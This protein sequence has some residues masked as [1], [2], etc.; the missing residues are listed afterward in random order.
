MTRLPAAL[1]GPIW[2]PRPSLRSPRRRSL[3]RV[4]HWGE[5]PP[6]TTPMAVAA[7][8]L[9]RRRFEGVRDAFEQ[10][11]TLARGLIVF[12]SLSALIAL[13][14]AAPELW[15]VIVHRPVALVEFSLVAVA[16]ASTP[17]QVYGRGSF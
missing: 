17:V 7:Q 2:R 14:F 10:E 13:A 8:P 9:R 4:R 16:L 12:T 15:Q 3:V 5:K 1:E 11:P 6:R